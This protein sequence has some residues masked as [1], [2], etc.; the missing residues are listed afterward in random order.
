LAEG[1]V[2][3][4]IPKPDHD[5]RFDIPCLGARTLETCAS[6]RIRALAFEGGRTLLLD[7]SEVD[8]LAQRHDITLTA[9]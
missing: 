1:A 6:A 5:L 4:K 7:E 2:A 3:V 9:I 8:A